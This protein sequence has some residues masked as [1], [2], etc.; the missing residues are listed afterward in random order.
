MSSTKKID[1]AAFLRDFKKTLALPKRKPGRPIIIAVAGPARI[2]KTTVLRFVQHKLPQF[3]RLCHD[4]MRLFL[5]HKGFDVPATEKF[6]YEAKPAV[7]LGGDFLR[8]GYGVMLD[9]NLATR[10]ENVGLLRK[11]SKQADAPFFVIR[12]LAPVG[13]VRERLRGKKTA[14]FPNWRVG[15]AHF[16][17]SRKQFNYKKFDRFCFAR[18]NTARPL[19]EQLKKPIKLLGEAMRVGDP[20]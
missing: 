2:G 6:L 20:A 4:D 18:V 16:E 14:L 13:V 19:G 5:H 7:R 1:S 12:A 17:R 15:L 9:A 10:P 3:V 8:E 11:F